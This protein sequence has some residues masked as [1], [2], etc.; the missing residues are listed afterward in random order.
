MAKAHGFE[1]HVC[2]VV[3]DENICAPR[4]GADGEEEK[5]AS[6]ASARRRIVGQL[7]ATDFIHGV[8]SIA[9][10]WPSGIPKSGTPAARRPYHEGSAPFVIER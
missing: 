8:E 7:L 6:N 1:E 10:G 4:F 9:G 5:M 3:F 2:T